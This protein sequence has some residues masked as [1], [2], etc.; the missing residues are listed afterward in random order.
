MTRNL[1]LVAGS[2]VLAVALFGCGEKGEESEPSGP[3]I[4]TIHPN[5][6]A[7][8]AASAGSIT[9][10]IK[11]DG[12]PP[13]MRRISMAAVPNCAKQHAGDPAMTEEVVPGDNGTLQ[14][15]VVYLQG[16]FNAYSFA[17]PQ[18]AVTLDQQGC[19]Y[20][21]HVLALMTGQPLLIV[22]SDKITHNV[23]P[24]PKYNRPWNKTE[25]PGAAPFRQSFDRPEVA[26]PVKCNIHPWMKAYIAVLDSP[27]FAVT[28]KDGSFTLQNVPPGSYKLVAW[29]EAY[30]E[31][32]QDVVVAAHESKNITLTFHASASRD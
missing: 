22:T 4:T 29:Q 24:I 3:P 15:V 27:Y 28:G 5:G 21:P 10:T 7:V 30:G 16:D 19:Q 18:T 8:D 25:S 11:L 26:I 2:I 1:A 6:K 14:N 12:A 32:S 13:A 9:G 31:V 20:R 17:V 23:H